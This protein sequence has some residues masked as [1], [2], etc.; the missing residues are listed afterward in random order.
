MRCSTLIFSSLGLL[1]SSTHAFASPGQSNIY[2]NTVQNRVSHDGFQ[3]YFGPIYNNQG[4]KKLYGFNIG[5][6]Y[7]SQ[8][9]VYLNL[10]YEWTTRGST[11]Q[12]LFQ[13]TAGII[14]SPNDETSLSMGAGLRRSENERRSS[15]RK[16]KPIEQ[17]QYEYQTTKDTGPVTETG[18]IWS[19]A[20]NLSFKPNY[21]Y[22]RLFDKR[23]HTLGISGEYQLFSKLAVTI[24]YDHKTSTNL[25]Q[26]IINWGFTYYL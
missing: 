17:C 10:D 23:F 21:S 3:D 7:V 22:S 15:C 24:D 5:G 16:D 19:V 26:N 12:E 9:N 8:S 11:T 13:G 20:N 2:L 18:V 4:S 14:Y 6:T 1:M 25:S